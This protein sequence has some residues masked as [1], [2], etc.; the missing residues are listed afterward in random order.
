[1]T[2]IMFQGTGSDVG[3]SMLVAGLCRALVRRGMRVRPFKPQNMSNN[4]AVTPEGGEIGRAQA[5]QAK[6]CGVPPSVE[7]NPVLLKPQTDIGAQVVVRGQMRG[8]ASA[9]EFF[10]A[11]AALMPEILQSFRSLEAQCDI[12]LIEGA[13]S[14]A[15]VNLRANDIANMGFAEAADVP[16]VLIGD[17]DRGGVIA[18]LVGS[19]VLISES[20]R[21]RIAGYLINKFRGDVSLFDPAIEAIRAR[22]GMGCLGVV[23]WF[24]DA[25]KLPAEDAMTLE[26][27][28]FSR[29]G[30][31][32][33]AA[34]PRISRIA[35]FD[36]LDPL[37]A[38]PDVD[39]IFVQSGE[40]IPADATVVI[41]P[42]SKATRADL[43]VIRT[44]GW[45]I[46]I[47]AHV[48]RGGFLVGLC[49][50][51]QSLGTTVSDPDG[52]EGPPGDTPGLGYLDLATSMRGKKVLR[53][54]AGHDHWSDSDIA[55]Y[56]MHVGETTGPG[57]DTP[58][59]T[60]GNTAVGAIDASGRV[61]GCYIHG[62]FASDGFRA[63]FL[64]HI[65]GSDRSAVEYDKLVET[66]LDKLAD[67]MEAHTDIDAI[68]KAAR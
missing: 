63:A 29:K 67:H 44:E 39:V 30:G 19:H 20:E 11:K 57:L 55:G 33:V 28:D 27:R 9:R 10:S 50:G 1:M 62:I 5:L 36:D 61:M 35:N 2:A 40:P 56:E 53:E 46:D 8:S 3:K 24:A 23:P 51:F 42:G 66:T 14:A 26:N 17:I 12:V 32:I 13:G 65:A 43:E 7:M 31:R 18:S 54:V 38:E 64:R 58:W 16:V 37:A 15:E 47:A 60:L 52:I 48:R 4:A 6:A 41:L 68:L 21:A 45:D 34:V 59:V 49:A 22:T 25:A